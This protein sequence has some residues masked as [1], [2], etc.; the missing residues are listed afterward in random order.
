MRYFPIFVDLAERAVL[1]AGA[2]EAALQKTRL[3]LKSD[4]RVRVAGADPHADLIELAGTGRIELARRDFV[5]GDLDGVALAYGAHEDAGLDA[6]LARAARAR[7]VPVN[8]VDTPELSDFITPA[9]ID[10]DPVTVAVG[11]EGTAPVL[12]RMIKARIEALLPLHLGQVAKKAAAL[13]GHIAGLFKDGAARRAAWSELFERGWQ[14][15]ERALDE[16]AANLP[17]VSHDGAT[18]CVWLVG[19]GPGDPELMT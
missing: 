4:A 12:A 15:G 13:R 2:G 18:G 5:P 1:V 16:A 6:A 11:T 10:R 19:A 3:A 9:I 8:V 7:S 17:G 14:G